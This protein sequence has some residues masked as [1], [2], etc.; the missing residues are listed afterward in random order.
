MLFIPLQVSEQL[1]KNGSKLLLTHGDPK[2][3]HSIAEMDSAVAD[4]QLLSPL[5][6]DLA[7]D[8]PAPLDLTQS[9]KQVSRYSTKASKRGL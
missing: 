2:E 5:V 3:E 4:V 6:D 7:S 1:A 8:L 9:K